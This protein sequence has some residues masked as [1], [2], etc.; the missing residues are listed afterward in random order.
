M[1]GAEALAAPARAALLRCME[2]GATVQDQLDCGSLLLLAGHPDA[3]RAVQ[4]AAFLC[5]GFSR[6]SLGVQGRVAA[7]SGLWRHAPPQAPKPVDAADSAGPWGATV[8]G[9]RQVMAGAGDLPPFPSSVAAM[10]GRADAGQFAASRAEDGA[11]GGPRPAAPAQAATLCARLH[12]ALQRPLGP[13][14][15]GRLGT[16]L[17]DIGQDLLDR[18]TLDPRTQVD[19]PLPMLAEAVVSV[20]LRRL[21]VRNWDLAYAPFGSP[22]LLH[23]AAQVDAGG[24]GAYFSAVPHFVRGSRDLLALIQLAAGGA[25]RDLLERW[26]LPLSAHMDGPALDD[27]A[28]ELAD[29]GLMRA[30]WGLLARA[31]RATEGT[32]DGQPRRPPDIGLLWT[33]RDA[34]LDNG[35]LALAV[36]AQRQVTRWSPHSAIELLVLGEIEAT[37]GDHPRAEEALLAAIRRDPGQQDA[38]SRLLAL[39]AGEFE[40]FK[41]RAGFGTPRSRRLI[42]ERRRAAG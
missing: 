36:Q 33:L 42:R 8:A 32:P 17:S 9:L 20:L 12:E 41:V 23:A 6:V 28:H 11:A 37:A 38:R 26:A 4:G 30:L 15:L 21:V 13:A 39:R 24:L 10:A 34:G 7:A 31:L 35:D 16:L 5:M 19:A 27:L 29:L 18:P 2:G 14:A 3:A 25:D 22:G 1:R 40:A